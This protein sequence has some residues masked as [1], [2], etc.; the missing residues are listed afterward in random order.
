MPDQRFTSGLNRFLQKDTPGVLSIK[1]SWGTGK[2]HYWKNSVKKEQCHE[3]YQKLAYI[4]LFG[5]KSIEEVEAKLLL[6]VFQIDTKTKWYNRFSR[7]IP[8]G[9]LLLQEL[10]S[11][12]SKLVSMMLI[13]SVSKSTICLDDLER[14]SK[15]L[16][17][18]DI[19]GLIDRLREINSCKVVL[20]FDEEHLIEDEADSEV[21]KRY[22]EKVFDTEL[23][24]VP[25]NED[26]CSIALSDYPNAMKYLPSICRVLE[27]ANIRI[28]R[29]IGEQVASVLE[30]L[31]KSEYDERLYEKICKS[32]AIYSWLFKTGETDA[33]EHITVSVEAIMNRSIDGKEKDHPYIELEEK[34]KTLGHEGTDDLDRVILKFVTEGLL[35]TDDLVEQAEKT[36][37]SFKRTRA[38]E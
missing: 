27:I 8:E 7:R 9:V 4:S 25:T 15:E 1:G 31:G 32:L 12:V 3:D 6:N 28:L 21:Y 35:D 34:I 10:Y 16:D 29:N 14:R 23:V 13:E 2:T 18:K 24:F 36:D 20:I 22:R 19:F 5:A 38:L 17:I 26:V 30:A 37:K 33:L 11:K